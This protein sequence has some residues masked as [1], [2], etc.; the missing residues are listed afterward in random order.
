GI[1]KHATS[2]YA[3]I[4]SIRHRKTIYLP[5]SLTKA[6]SIVLIQDKEGQEMRP[7]PG[8]LK[9]HRRI[10]VTTGEDSRVAGITSRCVKSPAKKQKARTWQHLPGPRLILSVSADPERYRPDRP[11]RHAPLLRLKGQGVSVAGIGIVRCGSRCGASRAHGL[12]QPIVTLDGHAYSAAHG[13]A[14]GV[15]GFRH[16]GRR[17]KAYEACDFVGGDDHVVGVPCGDAGRRNQ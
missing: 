17:R 3:P 16:P 4:A 9:N 11:S 10:S 14:H 7:A 5:M 12:L 15:E 13:A 1:L 2:V 8:R 6:C